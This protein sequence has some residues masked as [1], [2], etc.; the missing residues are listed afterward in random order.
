MS[1]QPGDE[2]ALLSLVA[3]TEDPM[4]MG[5]MFTSLGEPYRTARLGALRELLIALVCPAVCVGFVNDQGWHRL[6]EKRADEALESLHL[7]DPTSADVPRGRTYM[8]PEEIDAEFGSSDGT[9][10]GREGIVSD[11]DGATTPGELNAYP[12]PPARGDVP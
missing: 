10:K 4:Q 1:Y 2:G 5:P 7:F 6:C 9:Y 8:A 11:L 12:R 3:L